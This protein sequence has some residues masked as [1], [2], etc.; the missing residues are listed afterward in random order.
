MENLE[1]HKDDAAIDYDQ[2]CDHRGISFSDETL[3][4]GVGCCATLSCSTLSVLEAADLDGEMMAQIKASGHSKP[5]VARPIQ[6]ATLT[7][8]ACGCPH[9]RAS[10]PG[11]CPKLTMAITATAMTSTPS[12]AAV[13]LRQGQTTSG[14]QV[15]FRR[16]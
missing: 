6:L 11:N 8:E 1:E 2:E 16:T 4:K 10:R 15:R 9:F 13:D 3:C 7:A 14:P 12:P 5:P